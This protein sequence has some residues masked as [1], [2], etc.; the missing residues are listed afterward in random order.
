MFH[1]PDL[2]VVEAGDEPRPLAAGQGEAPDRRAVLGVEGPIDRRVR[3]EG[4]RVL[5]PVRGEQSVVPAANP[6]RTP[7]IV[8]RRVEGDFDLDIGARGRESPVDLRGAL[9]SAAGVE[10]HEV[11]D[12]EPAAGLSTGLLG[13]LLELGDQ[14][15]GALLVALG[16]PVRARL[17]RGRRVRAYRADR[18]VAAASMVEDPGED[19]RGVEARKA[20]PVDRPPAAHEGHGPHVADQRVVGDREVGRRA[21]VSLPGRS[22]AGF[23]VAF[24]VGATSP[25]VVVAARNW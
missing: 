4:E 17:V 18:E 5:D 10:R 19:T 11:D 25:S 14:D 15:V 9:G 8:E 21:Q 1:G 7:C 16:R 2:I 6:R 12:L 20:G 3:R 23:V 24:V 13:A 22:R